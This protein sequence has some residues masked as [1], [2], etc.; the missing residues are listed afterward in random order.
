VAR[1]EAK[2]WAEAKRLLRPVAY[3]PH[4]PADNPALAMLT[5]IEAGKSGSEIRAVGEV[6]TEATGE[7]P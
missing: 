1:I 7:Q 3:H 4:A 2:E 6:K 5:A